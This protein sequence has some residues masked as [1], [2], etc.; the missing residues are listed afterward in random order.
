MSPSQITDYH[1]KFFAFELTRQRRG[2]DVGRL[3]NSLFD[4]SVDLNP[5]QI[6]AALFAL[7]NPLVKG[8]VLA[9]EVG[10]GKTI[11]ASLV[12]AQLWAERKR[13]IVVICPAALRKQWANELAEKFHLPTQ[14]LDNKTWKALRQGGNPD[15]F[16][17][18]AISI[19]SYQF[20]KRME[21]QLRQVPW[22][23]VVI[24]EAHKLRNAHRDSNI[25]GNSL[26][27]TFAGCKKLLLTATP[28]QN[29]LLEL[30]GLSTIIDENL[31]GD[32]ASFRQ[33][34]MR[35]DSDLLGLKARLDEFI[36]RTLRKQ[37]LEYVPYTERKAYTYEFEPSED[38][39]RLYYSISAYLQRADSYGVPV[40]QRHLVTLVVRKLLASSTA[41]VRK[42]LDSLLKRLKKLEEK[43]SITATNDPW[44]EGL[45][46]DDFDDELL[47]AAEESPEYEVSSMEIAIDLDKLRG[48]IAE[49]E[50]YR[51]LADRIHEDA[52]SESLLIAL[53]QGLNKMAERGAE[54]KAVIFTES[55]R[56][57][58]YLASHLERHGYA[59]K[60]ALFSGN[61]NAPG[62]N[63]IYQQWL[64]VH[65]GT[66][67]VT[68]SRAVDVRTAIIDHFR[69]DAEILIATEAAAEGVN[70]QFCSLVIN[71]DLPWNPQRV[72]QRIGRCHRYGQKHDVVV[73]NFLNK[74]NQ[75][76]RRVLELLS[77]KFQLFDGLFGASDDVL[78]SIESGLD[79]EKRIVSIYNECRDPAEIQAAFD[80]LQ[81]ELEEDI[82]KR[83]DETRE[84]LFE[85]FD[86]NIHDKLKLRHEEAQLQLDQMSRMFWN[87]S[88]HILASRASFTPVNLTF[89]LDQ[90]PEGI[91]VP[92]GL[93][94]LT[95]KDKQLKPIEQAHKYR[96]GHPLG[97]WVLD[98]GRRLDTPLEAV[99]FD[100]AGFT[101]KLSSLEPL[102]GQAGWLELNQLQLSSFQN[103]EH[104]VFTAFTDDGRLLDTEQCA[105]LFLLQAQTVPL[106]GGSNEQTP[107]QTLEQNAKR[108]LDA[109]LSKLLDENNEYFKRERD[110][111]EAWAEDQMKS[112]Q[113]QLEDT[114]AE[115]Q[116]AKKLSRQAD[117]IQEQKEAQESIKKLERL[118]RRQRQ[119]IFDVEDA[120]EARRDALIDALEQQM[121]QKSSTQELFTIR[122]RLM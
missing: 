114:R 105:D 35:S 28:L 45:L 87:L 110:K 20:S 5:H 82:A 14:V 9:D 73:I 22:D 85:H 122:W 43:G 78:G 96:L 29:T 19:F 51:E 97:E 102:Q 65:K 2:G 48:E 81:Q 4:A 99:E 68:D 31:F 111:L 107:P 103:E 79:I 15:P 1:A 60:V 12:M 56:T 109:R 63:A 112:A 91:S 58:E 66:D 67:R 64:E 41:A 90:P 101:R 93:Y 76:D 104:L 62:T 106:S 44:P 39:M 57:Q 117:T 11:E 108:Q 61:N 23:L 92:P 36:H 72:E 59:G 118:Q 8:V 80:R 120:I 115:L 121:H 16:G 55:C 116:R 69:S 98:T 13:H 53:E 49:L 100:L 113:K 10:L 47:E 26:R 30:F 3:G 38:E 37:V 27:E 89:Q 71:Y 32:K 25:I 33:Q 88:R 42:T 77:H 70:L 95:G 46:D 52:K 50:Q 17:S 34:Y 54:R 74:Q 84:K 119:E 24:D 75:A 86:A 40:Q 83:M 7:Q 6:D 21:Q 94:Q 18:P